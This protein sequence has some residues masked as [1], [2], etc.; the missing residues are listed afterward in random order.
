[1]SLNAV[2]SICTELFEHSEDVAAVTCGHTFH[3]HCI[4]KWLESSRSCPQCRQKVGKNFIQKLYFDKPDEDSID[5]DSN[6]IKNDLNSAQAQL[7]AKLLEIKKLK[8]E[9]LEFKTKVATHEVKT[10]EQLATLMSFQKQLSFYKEK[11]KDYD[12]LRQELKGA[13]GELEHLSDIKHIVK[14]K[15]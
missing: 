9:L 10:K 3:N 1:M 6:K 11:T 5:I 2:C 4:N 8:D 15:I 14:G 13:R 7:K 12:V